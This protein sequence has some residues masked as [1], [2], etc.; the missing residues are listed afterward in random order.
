MVLNWFLSGQ[1]GLVGMGGH[2]GGLGDL[3][4]MGGLGFEDQNV[5]RRTTRRTTLPFTRPCCRRLVKT[6][7]L[8]DLGLLYFWLASLDLEARADF[9]PRC[10]HADVGNGG[11]GGFQD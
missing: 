4:G 2:Q 7:W 1:G 9:H 8:P 3:G 6:S 10:L 11:H 5:P